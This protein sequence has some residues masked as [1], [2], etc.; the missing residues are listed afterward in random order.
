M[1]TKVTVRTVSATVLDSHEI[2]VHGGRII[3]EKLPPVRTE[4]T[5]VLS[6][7]A[8]QLKSEEQR[9]KPDR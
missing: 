6:A 4:E 3:I 8:A 7:I 9:S 1:L 2:G 5:N